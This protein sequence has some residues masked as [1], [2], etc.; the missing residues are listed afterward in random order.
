M[1]V[2]IAGL[3]RFELGMRAGVVQYLWGGFGLSSIFCT[4]CFFG[5]CAWSDEAEGQIQSDGSSMFRAVFRID[6]VFDRLREVCSFVQSMRH[7]H[8]VLRGSYTIFI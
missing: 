8:R 3:V 5:C 7:L 2:S 4:F 6:C 1:G